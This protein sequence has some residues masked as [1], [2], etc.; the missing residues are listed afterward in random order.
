MIT[1][2]Y[3]WETD[4]NV[5]DTEIID[6]FDPEKTCTAP[7]FPNV[8]SGAIGGLVNGDVPMICDAKECYKLTSQGFDFITTT[9]FWASAGVA[10]QDK[11]LLTDHSYS[12][13]ITLTGEKTP[14]PPMPDPGVRYQCMVKIDERTIM[15]IGGFDN[16]TAQTTNKTYFLNVETGAWSRGPDMLVGRAFMG[17]DIHEYEGKR[18]VLTIGGLW[19]DGTA[20]VLPYIQAVES[21]ELDSINPQWK[22]GKYKYIQFI[23]H[24]FHFKA[25]RLKLVEASCISLFQIHICLYTCLISKQ[26]P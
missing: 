5:D 19:Y 11:L 1:T 12:E 13:F 25:F 21:L 24:H 16:P 26:F 14:G 9:S 17:C 7:D 22:L 4:S 18:Y 10:I 20:S 23:K 8:A 2:G 3:S 15:M 6:I